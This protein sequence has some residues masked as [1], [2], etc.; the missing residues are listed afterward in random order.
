MGVIGLVLAAGIALRHLAP[1]RYTPPKHFQPPPAAAPCDEPCWHGEACQVGRCEW[2]APNDVGHVAAEPLVAGPF[3]LPVDLVDVLP[4]DAERFAV[5]CMRGVEIYAARSGELLSLVSD[6]PQAQSLYRVGP[7]VYATSPERIH[8]IDV[9]TTRVLKSIEIGSPVHDLHVGAGGQRVVA[10]VPGALSVVVIATEYHAEVNRFFFGD[11]AV[12]PV[13]IDDT[14]SRGLATTGRS[15]LVGQRGFQGG[16]LYAFDPNRLASAQD[17]VRTAMMGNPVQVVMAQDGASSFVVLREQSAVVPL[18][19][20]A[21]SAVLRAEPIATC[22]KPEQL[23]MVP[24][25]RRGIV[26][27]SEGQAIEVFDL[28][29]REL[30]K[31]IPLHAGAS[32]MVVTPDSRQ[33]IV[34]LPYDRSGAVGLLDL[35]SYAL[36][37][38]ELSAEPRRVRLSPD[39]HAA[40]VVSDRTKVAWVL[41]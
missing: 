38:T 16:A 15:P 39:G 23:E 30:L 41:R 1:D 31:H 3:Q 19:T 7:V 33:A 29:R 32:D 40:V 24:V 12:G 17:R 37:L 22:R 21:S 27:C 9:E 35:Q 18:K 10:S 26:R 2:L 6:A 13:A 8:V 11:D 34:V 4:L 25:G 14:G 5:S 28:P 36:T 20:L